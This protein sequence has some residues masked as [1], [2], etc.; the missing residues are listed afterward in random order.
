[1]KEHFNW[2]IRVEV[3]KYGLKIDDHFLKEDARWFADKSGDSC[4]SISMGWINALDWLPG[5]TMARLTVVEK[6]SNAIKHQ[7]DFKVVVRASPYN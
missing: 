6:D 2:K 1:M 3:Y 7:N 4:E 5:E